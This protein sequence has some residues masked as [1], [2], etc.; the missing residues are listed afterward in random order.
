MEGI[1]IIIPVF[2]KIEITVKCIDLIRQLNKDCSF[3]IIIVDNGSTDA[4]QQTFT[5][6]A[7][8]NPSP[9][10]GQ[11][12]Y[13]R[14]EK[15]LGV[16]K[17]LNLGTESAKYDCLC[18]MHNDVFIHKK[19]WIAEICNFIFKTPAAGVVGLYG[20]KTIRKDGSFRGKTILHA[21]RG[22]VT[23]SRPFEKVAVVDGLLMAMNKTVFL[24]AG[25]FCE[26]FYIHYYDKDLSLR[27]VKNNF[28][29]YVLNIPFEH[30]CAATRSGIKKENEIRAAAQKQ[31]VGIWKEYLPVNASSWRERLTRLFQ[32]GN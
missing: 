4:T 19:K 20:A 17:A 22:F 32:T 27:A 18:F 5:S 23:M 6:G 3:E 9:A 30:Q 10:S 8:L 29:N 28:V 16:A 21:K 31:F 7:G 14:N 13:I 26:D 11:I 12:T 15:N 25:G 2:N 1:S 24:K